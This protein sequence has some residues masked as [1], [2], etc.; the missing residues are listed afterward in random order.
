MLTLIFYPSIKS[1]LL[2]RVCYFCFQQNYTWAAIPRSPLCV[3]SLLVP[4]EPSKVE[5]SS[6]LVEKASNFGQASDLVEKTSN[7]G[8][9]SDLV[10]KTSNFEQTSNDVGSGGSSSDV[11][12]HD[13]SSNFHSHHDESTDDVNFLTCSLINSSVLNV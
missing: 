3:K 7:L 12:D 10:E 11:N 9:T 1:N 5:K 2:L 4:N 6:N 8:Q 13:M